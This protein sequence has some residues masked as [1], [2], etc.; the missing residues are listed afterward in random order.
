MPAP[1]GYEIVAAPSEAKP[2]AGYDI[3]PPPPPSATTKSAAAPSQPGGVSRFLQGV[4]LPASWD[5]LHQQWHDFANAPS[6]DVGDATVNM[7]KGIGQGIAHKVGEGASEVKEAVGNIREGDPVL[8]ALGKAGY[9]ISHALL[10]IV[11]G[12]EAV[13]NFA[14]DVHDRNYSGATGDALATVV[15]ALM[16]RGKS[17]PSA[18][19]AV[20]KLGYA[21]G[22]E[23]PAIE[24]SLPEIQKTVGDKG[25][26]TVGDLAKAVQETSTR[27]DQKFNAGLAN[28]KGQFIPTEIADA[29]EGRAKM[30]P[31]SADGQAIATELRN[32]A[33]DYRK[34]WTDTQLNQERMLR[35]GM[36]KGFY[37]KAGSGQMAAMRS[38]AQTIADQ[39]IAD[40]AKDLLYGRMER[41]MPGQGFQS[42]KQQQSHLIDV[43]DQLD[44]QVDRLTTQQAK[45]KGAPLLEKPGLTVSAS[46]HGF[47]PRVHLG[48]YVE[49]LLGTGPMDKASAA[50][51]DALPDTKAA[52]L[53]RRAAV[54]ALPLTKLAQRPAVPPPPTSDDKTLTPSQQP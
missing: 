40:A 52:T 15:Q 4:G 21:A 16:L 37:N 44:A 47:T 34:P 50:V 38:S 1:A 53:K 22:G 14:N 29:L 48:S 3:V 23:V 35:N 39:T 43:M 6:H 27:L 30:Q 54:L 32:M 41:A 9:G 18:T 31:P 17:K 42:L 2:P 20:N 25:V 36:S 49:S 12:G 51:A 10:G 8:P 5:E 26:S 19:K 33:A 45:F 46:P 28:M 13:E 7:V 11:P 24:A